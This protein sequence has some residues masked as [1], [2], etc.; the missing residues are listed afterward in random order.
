MKIC[1]KCVLPET[2][3]GISF[4]HSGVCNYCND[5]IS[6]S[7][8]SGTTTLFSKEEELIE[9]LQ[10]Y[11]QLHGKYDVLVPIS[12]G[13]D[14]SAALINLVN[15]YGLKP[16]C[17]H[18]DHGYEDEVA[19]SNVKKLCAKLGV[20]LI[21]WQHDFRF[22]KKIWKY[23]NTSN[24]KGLSACYMCGNILYLNALELANSFNIKLVVNGYSKG[25]AHISQDREKGNEL[26]E[27]MI[28]VIQQSGDKEFLQEFYQKYSVLNKH[29]LMKSEDVKGDIDIEKITVIPFYMFKFYK[30]D[31]ES[32]KELCRKTFD[33]QQMKNTYPKRTTNCQMIWL[34]T[35]MDMKKMHYSTYHDEYSSLIREGEMTREQ[36]LEDLEFNPQM[37]LIETLSKEIGIDSASINESNQEESMKKRSQVPIIEFDF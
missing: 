13:V 24:I 33:W 11:K 7:D 35:Y 27:K 14:S 21:I 9:F 18:N 4:D 37:E 19:C 26:L 10:R 22:M 29:R 17:F 34:N 3:P 2:Y 5:H 16:L 20:D 6:K 32:L 15:K 1:K 31:K 23:L 12:G 8:E 30:T 36:A 25:Q 28:E